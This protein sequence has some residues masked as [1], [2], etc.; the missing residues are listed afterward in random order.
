MKMKTQPKEW[1]KIFTNHVSNK[2]LV[3]KVCKEHLP[4]NNKKI[5]NPIKEWAKDL[6][7]RFFKEDKW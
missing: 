4:L 1:E 7:G 6:N 2:G 5:D 3:S